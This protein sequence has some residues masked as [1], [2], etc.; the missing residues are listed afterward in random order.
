MPWRFVRVNTL[1]MPRFMLVHSHR[2]AE[3]RVAFAA[4]RGFDSPLRHAATAGSCAQSGSDTHRIWWA[5]D[6]PD[7]GSAVAHLPPWVAERTVAERVS[8]VTIP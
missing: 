6:A 3:C 5:V 8:Q 4:W 7:A 1:T 2:P